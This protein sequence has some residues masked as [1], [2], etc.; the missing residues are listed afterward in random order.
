METEFCEFC[1]EFIPEDDRADHEQGRD[2]KRP[3][4]PHQDLDEIV[5]GNGQR[6]E[7]GVR[8]P[9]VW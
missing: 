1:G 8:L 9:D 7:P 3:A 5:A 4:C 6:W 2:A